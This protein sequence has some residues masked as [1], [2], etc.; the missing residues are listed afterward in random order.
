MVN[1]INRS[2]YPANSGVIPIG[3]AA[4]LIGQFPVNSGFDT[5]LI[6]LIGLSFFDLFAWEVSR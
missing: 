1:P 2:V 6:N 4:D 5:G 3:M